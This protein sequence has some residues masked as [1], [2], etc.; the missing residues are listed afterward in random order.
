M[1]E[2]EVP[3]IRDDELTGRKGALSYLIEKVNLILFTLLIYHSFNRC[4]F[5]MI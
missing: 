5:L 4:G 3:T 1:I 2:E